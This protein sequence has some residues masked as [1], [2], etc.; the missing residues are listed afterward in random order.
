M[1]GK[2]LYTSD[3]VLRNVPRPQPIHILFQQIFCHGVK[4]KQCISQID[5]LIINPEWKM[6]VFILVAFKV[7]SHT[8]NKALSYTFNLIK[9][10]HVIDSDGMTVS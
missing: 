9:V 2:W 1:C 4:H 10:L 7:L 5:I 6:L 3:G 8:V